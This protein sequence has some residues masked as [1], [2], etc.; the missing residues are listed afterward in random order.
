MM[1]KKGTF[2]IGLIGLAIS[3]CIKHEVIPAPEPK[4]ELSANFEGYIGSQFVEYTENVDGYVPFAD[5]ATQSANG[6]NHAQYLF[7]M[8][9]A[10]SIP[11]IRIG[12]GSISWSAASGTAVPALDLFNSFYA[13]QD[14]PLYSDDAL[15]GFN[16]T[17]NAVDGTVWAS[18]EVSPYNQVVN[19]SNI[20]QES[21]N[22]G[23]YSKFTCTFSCYVYHTYNDPPPG[24]TWTDSILIENAVYQGWFKR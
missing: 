18:S 19:F 12:L 15:N 2:F 4:V 13:S 14:A 22:S 11:S 5:L 6:I 20:K 17:Y 23:D 24:I 3:S 1:L 7:S 9:S 21:D 8:V 10:S 16:V